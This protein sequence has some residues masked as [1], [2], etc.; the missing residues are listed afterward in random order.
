MN[1]LRFEFS[2]TY[3]NAWPKLKFYINDDLYHDYHFETTKGQ[4]T[5]P[6]DLLDGAHL[7]EIELYDKTSHH[8]VIQDNKITQD[9]LVTLEHIYL[10]NVLLPDLFLYR[11]HYEHFPKSLTWGVPGKWSF[12]FATPIIDWALHTKND[13]QFDAESTVV[14]T[15]SFQKNKKLLDLL[16]LLEQELQDV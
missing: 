1:H 3:C 4:V 10:D 14:S 16:D 6:I 9:Q 15:Y 5:L 11:G 8:T 13:N 2:A 7:L 12:K